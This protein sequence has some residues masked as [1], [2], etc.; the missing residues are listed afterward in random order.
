MSDAVPGTYWR[1]AKVPGTYVRLD[2][3]ETKVD[4]DLKNGSPIILMLAGNT[5][6]LSAR[7]GMG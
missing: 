1:V 4:N 6:P 3:P 7:N 5:A 2:I